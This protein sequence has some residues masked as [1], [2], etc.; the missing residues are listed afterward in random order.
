MAG[1]IEHTSHESA[2]AYGKPPVEVRGATLRFAGEGGFQDLSLRVEEGQWVTAFG[3]PGAGKS[4]LL[5]LVAGDLRPEA[6][7]VRAV[8]PLFIRQLLA[9]PGRLTVLQRL[10]QRLAAYGTPKTRREGRAEAALEIMGLQDLR[11]M[12]ERDTTPVQRIMLEL[13]FAIAAEPPVLLLDDVLGSVPEPAAER[14]R[15]FLDGR[16]AADGMAVLHATASSR[17]AERSDRVLILHRGHVLALEDTAGLVRDYAPDSIT[18]EAADP[19]TVQRTLRGIFD[20]EVVETPQGLRIAGA[21]STAVAAHL[22]RHPAGGV[23]VIYAA[24]GDLWTAFRALVARASSG[25]NR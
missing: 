4:V 5:R 6:G 24:R 15:S 16:R 18:V 19:S 23:R 21:D 22:L 2:G 3:P 20:V 7:D 10:T 17:Q 9:P 1:N 25:A 13:V 11:E 12:P 14:F 8:C